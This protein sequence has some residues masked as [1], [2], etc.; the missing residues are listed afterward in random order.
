[1]LRRRSLLRTD[2]STTQNVII[3]QMIALLLK[4]PRRQ[5][6][7]LSL[8]SSRQSLKEQRTSSSRGLNHHLSNTRHC[9]PRLLAVFL[10]LPQTRTCRLLSKISQ[11][12]TT[13]LI[14]PFSQELHQL[15]RTMRAPSQLILKWNSSLGLQPDRL[16][17]LLNPLLSAD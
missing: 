6:K 10:I 11:H 4:R 17:S 5:S 7:R 3:L 9:Q 15:V 14:A 16:R 1:M 13:P 2:R 8:E 12:R